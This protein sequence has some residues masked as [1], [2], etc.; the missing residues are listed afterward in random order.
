[1]PFVATPEKGMYVDLVTGGTLSQYNSIL[2]NTTGTI[3]ENPIASTTVMNFAICQGLDF[4]ILY[5]LDKAI[6]TN[7]GASTFRTSFKPKLA[8]F[9]K[10]AKLK[11]LDVGCARSTSLDSLD[12]IIDF[13]NTRVD[14]DE[15]MTL[16]TTEY[17]WWFNDTYQDFLDMISRIDTRNAALKA[18][19]IARNICYIGH[20]HQAGYTYPLDGGGAYDPIPT[21]EVA[22]LNASTIDVLAFHAY[23]RIPNYGYV[24]DRVRAMTSVKDVAWIISGESAE[25]N[26][27]GVFDSVNS[28]FE[29]YF[30]NGQQTSP[31]PP[32]SPP[33]VYPKK[34]FQDCYD[35]ITKTLASPSP[36]QTGSPISYAADTNVNA[37]TNADVKMLIAFSWENIYIRNM[38][39][40]LIFAGTSGNQTITLPVN[41]VS[42][43]GTF[44]DDNLPGPPAAY[45][46]AWTQ[47]SGP[48]GATISV[49]NSPVTNIV[50]TNPGVY[51]FRFTIT[52]NGGATAN[53]T[54]QITVNNAAGTTL[55]FDINP[56]KGE[57]TCAGI[58]DAELEAIVTTGS[59]SYSYLWDTG[60]TT[61]NTGPTLC[62][63]PH[64]CTVTD[65]V[66][67]EV[68]TKSYVIA[69][70]PAIV[71]NLTFTNITCNGA[72]NGT[73]AVAPTG[74]GGGPYTYEWRRLLP[75]PNV[76]ISTSAG[77][78]GLSPGTYQIRIHD[79]TIGPSACDLLTNVVI[80]EPTAIVTVL[81]T[82]PPTCAGLANGGA[83][84]VTT[85]GSGVYTRQWKNAALTVIGTGPSITGLVA[86][87]YSLV[88]T[89]STGCVK[90]DTFTIAAGFTFNLGYQS[91]DEYCG[92]GDLTFTVVNG[93]LPFGP[94]YT[95]L[96]SNGAT[97]PTITISRP[98]A[99][100][101]SYSVTVTSEAGCVGT[102]DILFDTVG[103]PGL[104]L[105]IN[106]SGILSTCVGSTAT[107]EPVNTVGYEFIE[108]DDLSDG[109][110]DRVISAP[111]TYWL[112]GY[113][114]DG[115]LGIYCY[116]YAEITVVAQNVTIVID[117]T[118]TPPVCDPTSNG[119][120]TILISGGCPTYLAQWSNGQSGLTLNAPPGTYTVVVTDSL[121]QVETL[122]VTI[123]GP[124]ALSVALTI[125]PVTSSG[126]NDGTASAIAGG[127]N[128]PYT[129]KWTNLSGSTLS[130]TS[131]VT[132]LSPGVYYVI[133]TDASG[134]IY[135]E[136]FSI[137]L[138]EDPYDFDMDEEEFLCF[139]KTA[140][141]CYADLVWDYINAERQGVRDLSC[142]TDKIEAVRNFINAIKCWQKSN[143][144]VSLGKQP[145]QV[146]RLNNRLLP[147]DISVKWNGTTLSTQ[148]YVPDPT[149]TIELVLG[150]VAAD[151]N[152]LTSTT[153][154][155]AE[156]VG[157]Y[158]F[159]FGPIG[160]GYNDLALDFTINAYGSTATFFTNFTD[161]GFVRGEDPVG[162]TIVD[163]ELV[164]APEPC[165]TEKQV[166]MIIEKIKKYCGCC[167]CKSVSDIIIDTI[168]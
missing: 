56:T 22:T 53:S 24:K 126:L 42:V 85:G 149:E 3:D 148:N 46:A 34:S 25:D 101:Y 110:L 111:G 67:G 11:G 61:Q 10:K 60:Q 9:V 80:T 124:T 151:V 83:S 15:K 30:L 68:L 35:Y 115:N 155:S 87:N 54:L 8:H 58:C 162:A 47:V 164:L 120:A 159:F 78:T 150:R 123:P 7:S 140:N 130:T 2:G 28:N 26:K 43:T 55:A 64:S 62:V 16:W 12:C 131:S 81:T 125:T 168:S 93:G 70:P 5:E 27:K 84:V 41:T 143:H 154:I 57:V 106:Q 74:G 122:D 152:A 75:L 4:L 19:G 36:P 91:N 116:D 105:R 147:W 119:S 138:T 6:F 66:T 73:A 82:N 129:Y 76:A 135:T 49:P 160:S 139:L 40:G 127:G 103:Q 163:G 128:F 79:T 32:P 51:V 102:L 109:T 52:D 86:G 71:A 133:V 112:K 141:C 117:E 72:N 132:G 90:T 137:G 107:L 96:W 23:A 108:W 94:G 161:Y 158:L 92:Q 77:V 37:A 144:I 134:C 142:F 21:D 48:A 33:Y 44:I 146:V 165:L 104:G 98:A 50:F 39:N 156:P 136:S 113:V 114:M 157:Q 14:P 99:G 89:D 63:G 166:G 97:T 29:G 59:G 13:N 153:G 38:K 145:Y 121:G 31:V 17:E 100:S 95:F 20:C 65:T 69:A 118:V 18:A 45:T 167:N 88:T 1:M